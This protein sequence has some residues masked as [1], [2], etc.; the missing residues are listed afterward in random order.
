MTHQAIALGGRVPR[1]PIAAYAMLVVATLAWAGN[2]I[3]GRALAGEVAPLSL[4][5]VRWVLAL[6]LVLPFT[7]RELLA[8]RFLLRRH[9]VLIVI[10]GAVGLAGSNGLSYIALTSTTAI[11]AGLINS[12]QPAIT[13]L[14]V[15]VVYGERFGA[16]QLAGVAVSLAGVATLVVH[17][18]LG[19]LLAVRLNQGDLA[20]FVASAVWC[21]YSLLF[22]YR[23]LELSPLAFLTTLFA[24]AAAVLTPIHM[25][26]LWT[27]NAPLITPE[28]VAGMLYVGVFPSIVAVL[29]WNR[30]LALIG[31]SRA[32]FFAHLVPLFGAVLAV[33]FLGERLQ[34]FHV[35]GGAL[36]FA[37]IVLAARHS[38]R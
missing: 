38:G 32:S 33:L 20:Q 21:G 35:V 12:V 27:G 10:L 34:A 2:L 24:A 22:R 29:C 31:P 28:T 13:L 36:I 19:A 26:L 5:W 30:A 7:W 15:A 9:W 18:N 17:G 8:R 11:N 25:Y 23:P 4:S 37:G 6:L 14:A 16:W 3:A 1:A